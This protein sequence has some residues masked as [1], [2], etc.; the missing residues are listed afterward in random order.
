MLFIKIVLLL[1]KFIKKSPP[2]QVASSP[3]G[4]YIPRIVY[5]P[6]PWLYLHSFIATAKQLPAAKKVDTL[7]FHTPLYI[8]TNI[9]IPARL[10]C[11]YRDI[12]K[13]TCSHFDLQA[14]T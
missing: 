6:T 9:Y 12:L 13:L 2:I 8:Q 3:G 14:R 10:P 1:I 5:T 4:K 7:N 11:K